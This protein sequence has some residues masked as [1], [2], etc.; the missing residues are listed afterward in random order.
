MDIIK[1]TPPGKLSEK[2]LRKN[3]QWIIEKENLDN[4]RDLVNTLA[5]ALDVDILDVASAL[6]YLHQDKGASHSNNLPLT[7][8]ERPKQSRELAFTR[9]T[10]IKMVRYR[11]EVGIKHGVNLE[12]LKKTLVEESGVDKNNINNVD[13]KDFYTLIELPDEMPQDIFE[14]LKSVEIN[15]QKLDIKRIKKRNHLKRTH[16]RS[17]RGRHRKQK[18]SADTA[19]VRYNKY[20]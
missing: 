2:T 6:I 4:E 14:H 15:Q 11:L 7:P 9:P 16:Q 1:N 12:K 5:A 18:T 10:P 17:G 19:D 13:I 3:L 8:A 20:Q